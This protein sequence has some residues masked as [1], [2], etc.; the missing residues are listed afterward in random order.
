VQISFAQTKTISGTVSDNSGPLPGVSIIIKGTTTGTET[1]FDG[2]YS[3]TAK[4]GDVLT[5]R[6]LGYKTVSKTVGES[7][8]LNIILEEG[9]EVLDE[10]VVTAFGIKREKKEISYVVEKVS[11]DKL[12]AVQPQSAASALAGKVAG[13]QI[14]VQNNGVNPSTQILLRGMR[15]I[16]QNNSALIV[17]DGSIAT[18]GA[19]DQL[20]P[21][22]IENISVLKGA[23]AAALYGSRAGNGALIVNT[24]RGDIGEKITVGLN[25]SYTIEEVSFMPDM[26]ESYGIGWQGVYDP[27]ENTNWGPAFDGLTRRVGPVFNDG[28]YQTLPY[29]PIKD[30]LKDFY[31][32]GSSSQNTV[33]LSGSDEKNRFY[34]SLGQLDNSGIVPNDSYKRNTFRVNASRTMGDVTLSVNT[35][36][37]TD[38][39][40]ITGQTI[41]EQERPLYWFVLN[42]PANIPLSNYKD[43]RN[44][45]YSSPDGFYNAYYQNPY[46]AIDTNRNMDKSKR[47]NGNVSLNWDVNSWLNLTGRI[48]VNNLTR[49]GKNYR[50]AQPYSEENHLITA[51]RPNPVPSFVEDFESQSTQ[52]TTDFLAEGNFDLSEKFTLKAILG[53]TNFTSQSRSSQYRANNLS[54][55]GFYDISNT[56]QQLQGSVNESQKKTYGLFGDVTVGYD[57]MLF[58]NLSGRNDWTSTLDENNNSYFYP[59]VGLSFSFADLLEFD[60]LN[61]GKFTVSNSTVYNDVGPY[62][63]NET[64]SQ[65]LGF[66][67]SST[68]LNGFVI[69]GTAVDASVEKEKIATLEFGLGL[70]LFNNRITLDASYYT[71]T[72]TDLITTATTAPSAGSNAILTNIGSIEGDSYELSLGLTP[73]KALNKG[74]FNWNLNTNF[75]TTK[76]TVT[77]IEEGVDEINVGGSAVAG[78]Y[79]VVGEAFPQMKATSYERDPQGRVVIDAATGNPIVGGLKSLGQTTPKYIVGLTNAFSFKGFTL[80]TTMDYRT[81]HVYYSQLG[82]RME[83]TGRSQESVSANRQDFI[84]PNSV[85]NT[86]TA[87]NPVFVANNN[88]QTTG[89]GQNFWTNTY[90]DI[91]ENY[92]KDATSLKIREVSL[93]YELPNK[94]INETG[95]SK[96]TVGLIARNLA[97]WLPKENRFSDPEFNNSS[98]NAIGIGGYLQSPP[99]RSFGLNL[100]LEF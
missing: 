59:S 19:F 61:Y 34:V 13:L 11:T 86:G 91:K 55:P 31:E 87:E 83:F 96:V 42:N 90:N 100:N 25:S 20:N 10:I 99:T 58:L 2:N 3:L 14:N 72:T 66:P 46:W 68:G 6:Y 89:G 50:D 78:V 93:R 63:I 56:T 44:D 37:T 57:D 85:T 62:A 16:S 92:I 33:Y 74:D 73:F 7:N 43:W 49:L 88:I 51:G 65:Q 35:S 8:T 84:F 30:N 48:G 67:Y 4:N 53:A 29:A 36:Y 94:Y 5:F 45:L 81:G 26:Q 40:D 28:S 64:Y 47:L 70:G 22:D 77:E 39:T 32:K 97:V 60:D 9:G 18:Q 82:D 12:L 27:Y 1:D 98:G 69:A 23:T 95:L 71:S 75:T 17:I 15:S 41:A 38:N 80:T 52:Y 76:Q 24:K 79:A 21:N 54:I